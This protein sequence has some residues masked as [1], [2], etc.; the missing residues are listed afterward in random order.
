[1]SEENNTFGD[2]VETIDIRVG[3]LPG[4]IHPVV[5]NGDRSVRAALT[6]ANIRLEGGEIF[7][8]GTKCEDLDAVVNEGDTILSTAPVA[9][10]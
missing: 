10:A 6:A 7:I 3:R 4:K 8:N 9:G 1:M 5:L 2:N